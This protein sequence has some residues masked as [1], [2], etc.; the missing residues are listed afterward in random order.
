M[1]L[2]EGIGAGG[3]EQAVLGHTPP[4]SAA[5]RD[6]DTRFTML[7]TTSAGE[8]SPTADH[9]GGGIE[10]EA[11]GEDGKA[12]QQ[13]AFAHG[14]EVVAPVQRGPQGLV[15]RQRRAATVG[16]QAKTIVQ[17]RGQPFDTEHRRA[18]RRQLDRQGNA[19]QAPADRGGHRAR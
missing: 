1:Q 8:H 13:H 15:A 16:Q 9:V 10:R 4:T 18:R 19:V 11:A 17:A 6:F 7:S 14:Q 3:L 2:L 12:A 5:T